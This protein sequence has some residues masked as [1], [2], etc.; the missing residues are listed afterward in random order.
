MPSWKAESML[1]LMT[2]IWGATFLF[3][4][5]GLDFTGP[6]LYLIMRFLIA[7]VLTV[8]VFWKKLNFNDPVL[9]KNG[10][11]LG[12]IFGI[13]FILQT[14]GL[15]HTTIQKSA[16]ITGLTVVIT[17]FTFK[18]L[19]KRDILLFS[20]IGVVIAFVG[21]YIFTD[22]DFNDINKGDVYTF[23]S[24]FCWAI[25]IPLLD[26]FTNENKTKNLT[27]NLVFL[28][29]VSMLFVV[30]LGFFIFEYN[31]AFIIWDSNLIISVLFNGI[32]ASFVLMFIHTNFQKYT[33]PVKAALI[34]SLEPIFAAGFALIF[35]G[36]Y[37]SRV[38]F[39]GA[40]VLFS[41]VLISELG[42]PMLN[43]L[44]IGTSN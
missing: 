41:G 23:L 15:E 21:L 16:F 42:R 27:I 34:F 19:S 22:P 18:L 20:K 44:K 10:L 32:L 31:S 11:L 1:L 38:E 28:Q 3:I 4:K 33:T 7:I 40:I 14:I 29:L 24:T 9:I 36:E 43:M 37:L 13:G 2:V 6:F 39:I 8:V 5:L 30:T 35:L 12:A 26:K 17:P 25:F